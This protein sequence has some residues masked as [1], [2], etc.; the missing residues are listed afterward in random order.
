MRRAATV[1]LVLFLTY[2]AGAGLPARPGSQL[3]APEARQLLV[4]D[5]IVRDG[6]LD[7]T[8]QYARR[9]WR[10]WHPGTLRPIAERRPAGLLA[11]VAPGFALLTAPAYA[12]GG[13][14]AV[15]LWLAALTALG[16]VVAATLARRLVPD[17]WA[18][19]GALAVGLSPPAVIAATTIGPFGAG[20][21]AIAGAAA[22]AL[23]AREQP[24][25]RLTAWAGVLLGTLPWLAL[26]LC[27]PGLV[28]LVAMFRWARRRSRALAGLVGAEVALFSAVLYAS[29][30]DRLFGGLTPAPPVLRF[31]PLTPVVGLLRWTPVPALALAS[32]WLLWRSRREGLRRVLGEQVDVEVAAAFLAAIC[33][34]GVVVAALVAPALGGAAF[35]GSELVPVLPCAAALVAWS[36]RRLPRTGALLAAVTVA[37]TAWTLVG[38]R[39][40]GEAGVAPPRGALPFVR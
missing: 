6:D 34:A 9:A 27:A 38:A 31:E 26:R 5:S 4:T 11:P 33:A 2:A 32:L 19:G 16:F 21:A 25:P 14:L 24:L 20:S 28:V 1:W 13:R 17:P 23:S 15:E 29:V 39:L 35:G 37:L 3:S 12:A 18:T 22:I 7:L 30:N 8:N 10:T 40:D 36:L